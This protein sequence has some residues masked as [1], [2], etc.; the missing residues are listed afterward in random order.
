MDPEHRQVQVTAAD[1]TAEQVDEHVRDAECLTTQTL[2]YKWQN[3]T[4]FIKNT[5]RVSEFT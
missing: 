2:S 1:T 4:V 3:R 5:R